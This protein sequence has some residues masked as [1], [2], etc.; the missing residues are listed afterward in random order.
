MQQGRNLL[1]KTAQV[2]H[3][4]NSGVICIPENP[5]LDT[6]AAATTLYL[7]LT[8]LG[9]NVSIACASEV[10]SDL[11]AAD[12]IQSELTTSGENLVISFPYT[13]GS[14]D[15]IDYS[16]QTNRFN[17]I[18]TPGKGFP[19]LNSDEVSFSYAGGSVDFIITVDATSLRSL[20]ALYQDH[21][22][23]FNGK[24][25]VNIGRNLTNTF[26]GTVNLVY[27]GISST[28]EIIL[29]ILQSLNCEIDKDIATNLYQGLSFATK[30]FTSAQ[31]TAETFETAAYLLKS[32]A[33]KT[34]ERKPQD[35]LRKISFEKRG[36]RSSD[37]IEKEPTAP[38]DTSEADEEEWLK[39]KIFRPRGD[40][41]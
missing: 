26:F 32:G 19:K 39:P 28:S 7:G 34:R 38:E 35:Q 4:S 30:N 14:T 40:M 24:K 2:L 10:K 3:E 13:D 29:N 36:S 25:I 41:S 1:Q 31:I 18:V 12:K 27:R 8:K 9:K 5:T 23:L 17:I 6:L 21:E 15:R 16:I 22:E 33:A 11:V 20:G 37:A